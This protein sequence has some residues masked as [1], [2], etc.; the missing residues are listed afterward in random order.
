VNTGSWTSGTNNNL[1]YYQ[2]PWIAGFV[3]YDGDRDLF[4]LNF[5]D[6]TEATGAPENWYFDIQVQIQAAASPVEYSWT[7]FRDA[8][9]N[10]V[11]VERTFWLNPDNENGDFE[12]DPDGEGIVASWADGTTESDSVKETIPGGGDEFRIGHRWRD[13]S[14]SKFY[15][16]I[17]DFNYA[18]LGVETSGD[19]ETLIPI[20]NQTPDNDWGNTNSSVAPYRFQVTVTYHPDCS[21]PDECASD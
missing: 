18:N 10:D 20:P 14:N 21:S 3:D 5:D 6:I 15:F 12:F 13:N 7:L 8:N 9:P 2:S 16:S 11:L 17:N 4:E 1:T 19:G